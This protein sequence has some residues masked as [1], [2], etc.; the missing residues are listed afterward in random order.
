MSTTV[1][2]RRVEATGL[3]PR[4]FLYLGGCLTFS[5][6]A[7]GFIHAQLGTDPLDVLSQGLI[8][9]ISWMT[10]GIA[11]SGFAALCIGIWAVWNKRPPT[12]TRSLLSSSVEP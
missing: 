5:L 10:S 2:E 12:L 7:T 6:G 9:K 8:G 4:A 3:W 11:Q 1:P